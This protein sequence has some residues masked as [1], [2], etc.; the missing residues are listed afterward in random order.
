MTYS[1]IDSQESII[2]LLLGSRNFMSPT[3]KVYWEVWTK[4]KKMFLF[5]F[6]FPLCLNSVTF[7][8]TSD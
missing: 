7:E 1:L 5:L 4:E 6:G 2:S 8:A 3:F